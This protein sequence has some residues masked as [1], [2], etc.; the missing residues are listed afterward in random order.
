MRS[1][2]GMAPLTT[3]VVAAVDR[4][5]VPVEDQTEEQ[6]QAARSDVYR[7]RPPFIWFTGRPDPSVGITFGTAPARDGYE[8]PLR[9]YRPRAL[10]D[11]QNDIPVIVYF[12]GGGWV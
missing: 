7:R 6:R 8:I 10:R 1:Y 12:H 11:S 4:L 5:R 2:R 3:A 9:L